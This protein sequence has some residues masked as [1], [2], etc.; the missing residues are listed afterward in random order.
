MT[1]LWWHWVILGLLLVA[2]EM[3]APGGFFIIFFGVAAILTGLLAA[4]GAA[5]PLWVQLLLF[6][7][8]SVASLW[9][10]RSRLM[11]WFEQERNGEPVDAL[12]GQACR[13]LGDLTPRGAGQVELRGSAWA[14]RNGSDVAIGRDAPCRVVRVEGLTLH[15]EPEGGHR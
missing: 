9:L 11:A 12:V 3:A 13:A 2:A 4:V 1:I 10:F 8:L 15:V 14:A 7:V 5:G 6:S